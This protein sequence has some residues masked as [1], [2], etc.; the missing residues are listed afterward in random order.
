MLKTIDYSGRSAI[1]QGDSLTTRPGNQEGAALLGGI[2][3]MQ[4]FFC[5][6]FTSIGFE[7]GISIGTF[8]LPAALAAGALLSLLLLSRPSLRKVLAYCAFSFAIWAMAAFLCSLIYDY[9]YDGNAYHQEIIAAVCRGWVSGGEELPGVPLSV[10][11]QHYTRGMELMQA[12]VAAFSSN[13]ESGKGINVVLGLSA[14]CF[15]FAFVREFFPLYGKV[16]GLIFSFAAVCNPV[17]FSQISTFYIDFAKYFYVLISIICVFRICKNT[18]NPQNYILLGM[19]CCLSIA[20]KYNAF[21]DEG[22]VFLAALIWLLWKGRR[23]IAFN[24]ALCGFC[25]LALSLPVLSADPYITNWVNAGHPLYPLMGEG[26]IDI[27]TGNTPE[28]YLTINR[29]S[30]FIDSLLT[31]RATLTADTKKGGFGPLMAPML[32]IALYAII[33]KRKTFGRLPIYITLWILLSCFAFE[34]TWW[35]RY[36]PQLWLIVAGSLLLMG[37]STQWK[38][39]R[40]IQLLMIAS[41]SLIALSSSARLTWRFRLHRD[42]ICSCLKEEKI[43]M[44]GANEAFVM[45]LKERGITVELSDKAPEGLIPIPYFGQLSDPEHAAIIYVDPP[46][47][48]SIISKLHSLPFNYSLE[49]DVD[50]LPL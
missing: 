5:F 32:L 46:T 34:Q 10:W 27:M 26:N 1:R 11:A 36:M 33:R 20:T 45:Q 24:L 48:D 49:Y 40:T 30:S 4:L 16:R 18:A 25:A 14:G 6:A 15:C 3:L 19:S 8:I 39:L 7:L 43:V 17:Y 41:T 31:P 47:H 21:F 12:C 35:A 2:L 38:V 44:A 37:D 23:N 22:I 50:K 28:K 9:S 42:T 13:L 29:F